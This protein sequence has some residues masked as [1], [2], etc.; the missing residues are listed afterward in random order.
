LHAGERNAW[1]APAEGVEPHQLVVR[2]E[3]LAESIE[4]GHH[5]AGARSHTSMA[6]LYV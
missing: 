4:A 3:V 5:E 1:F 6:E 2:L